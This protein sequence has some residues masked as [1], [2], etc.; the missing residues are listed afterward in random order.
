MIKKRKAKEQLVIPKY[1]MSL[2]F[3]VNKKA[4]AIPKLGYCVIQRRVTPT[5]M[6]RKIKKRL[7]AVVNCIFFIAC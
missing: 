3:F 5:I 6:S 1:K 4:R 2:G 7:I